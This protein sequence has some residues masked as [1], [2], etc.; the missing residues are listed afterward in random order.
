MTERQIEQALLDIVLTAGEN[1]AF[2]VHGA[3]YV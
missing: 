3:K 2:Y 1:Y